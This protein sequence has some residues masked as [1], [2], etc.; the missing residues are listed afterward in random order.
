MP[1]VAAPPSPVG[2]FAICQALARVAT[3][4]DDH[5]DD[6]IDMPDID[7]LLAL[8]DGVVAIALTLLVLQLQ[9]PVTHALNTIP[10]PPGSCGHAQHRWRSGADQLSRLLPSSWHNSGSC[11]TAFSAA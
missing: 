2:A 4:A 10:T 3:D 6:D 11:T 9:V 8:T 7:R 5:D 1:R